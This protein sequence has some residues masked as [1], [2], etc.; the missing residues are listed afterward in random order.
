MAFAIDIVNEDDPYFRLADKVGWIISNMGSN[1]ITILDIAPWGN[2][3]SPA[4]LR[5][6][7]RLMIRVTVVEHVSR[8]IGKFIPSVKYVHNYATAFEEFHQRP[9][10]AVTRSFLSSPEP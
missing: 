9:F 5:E 10:D 3:I 6:N 4:T 7:C 1:G 8:W 2:T